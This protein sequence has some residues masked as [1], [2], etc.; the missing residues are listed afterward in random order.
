MALVAAMAEGLT[1]ENPTRIEHLWQRLYRGPR[2]ACGGPYM[3]NVISAIAMALWDIA[4]KAWGVPV[5]WLLGGPRDFR[6]HAADGQGLRRS[7]Q[8]VP[9]AAGTQRRHHA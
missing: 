6:R 5:Y 8:G 3:T 1:G 4:G 7:H 2:D 9:Q